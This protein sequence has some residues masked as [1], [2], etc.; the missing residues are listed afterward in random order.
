MWL[1]SVCCLFCVWCLANV[2]K[3]QTWHSK[4]AL[5]QC[6]SCL[7]LYMIMKTMVQM[8]IRMMM[9]M[10]CLH[11]HRPSSSSLDLKHS[12]LMSSSWQKA[13][14]KHVFPTIVSSETV[15]SN[16]VPWR[17]CCKTHS[18]HNWTILGSSYWHR[19]H[20]QMVFSG[21]PEWQRFLDIKVMVMYLVNYLL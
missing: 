3:R 17:S 5:F 14:S 11:L 1:L 4:A 12:V 21:H 6:I 15:P 10:S 18:P 13:S 2:V 16:D 9:T 20:S 7:H 8:K 19:P